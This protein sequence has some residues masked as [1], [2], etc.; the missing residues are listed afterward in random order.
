MDLSDSDMG[1]KNIMTWDMAISKIQQGIRGI[2]K[3]ATLP[4]LTIDMQHQ[5]PLPC[6]VEGP[7]PGA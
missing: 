6:P 7:T 1:P 5:D 2:L 3:H 4:F